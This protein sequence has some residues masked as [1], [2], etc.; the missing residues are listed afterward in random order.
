MENL[1]TL[2]KRKSEETFSSLKIR[3]YR[4][5]YI[6]QVISTSGT[7]MQTIAQGWLVLQL[8]HSGT[9]LGIVV[10]LQYLPLLFLGPHG[11][12]VAD[13]YPKRTILYFTQALSGLLALI[14][15]LLVVT[16]TVQLWMVIVLAFLLG[17]VSV[18]D[19]PTRQTFH[20]E[21][22]GPDKLR[23][24]VTLYSML[25]NLSRVIGPAI[26][27][28][29]IAGIGI[30]ACFI[31]N[32]LSYFAVVIMLAL[33]KKDEMNISEP[34]PASKGQLKEGI[35]YI[36][37]TPIIGF[38]LLMMALIGTFTFEF[39]VS[40]PLLAQKTFNSDAS[41]YAFLTAALGVGAVAGGLYFASKKRGA[42]YK[43]VGAA[44]LFGLS[45]LA[46][47]LMPSLF[48][49]GLAL[50]AVGFC[51]IN[52]ST[53][54]NTT[55]QLE[56]N[57]EMRGRIMAFWSIAFLGSTTFG[58]PIIGWF[59]ESAGPRWGLALGGIVAIIAAGIGAVTFKKLPNLN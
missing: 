51:M 21:L 55:L 34:V 19:N 7:F 23:N 4:L 12:V 5:Y 9:A 49:S 45:I 36:L 37:S 48:S 50:V 2:F 56:C 22:V 26:A 58:G 24:A 10:A 44:L 41:G 20:I 1:I 28:G 38:P 32:G 54:G 25:V 35:K 52:F 43:L 31:I 18:Y 30:G 8:T 42:P 17:I 46:A 6:G 11:G 14:L 59:A 29:L 15:G 3:N 57:P 13:R 33:M 40:L 27:A 47:S 53:L 39:Q 16:N